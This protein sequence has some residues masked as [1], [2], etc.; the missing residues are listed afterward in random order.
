[1]QLV[2]SVL[3]SSGPL[4]LAIPGI[5]DAP[6]LV[7]GAT[8]EVLYR[9]PRRYKLAGV[10]LM[11]RFGTLD[12]A[13]MA[14]SLEMSVIDDRGESLISDS[15]GVQ[16]AN[17]SEFAPGLMF[18]GV[19][20]SLGFGGLSGSPPYRPRWQPTSIVINAGDSWTIKVRNTSVGTIA[21]WLGFK[22]EEV[23]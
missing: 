7:A 1:M 20:S 6:A 4:Y 14:A 2:R 8:A 11:P 9:W 21:P 13:V 12:L 5:S 3:P 16:P 23:L 19:G 22:L 18:S 10:L 17:G 15:V